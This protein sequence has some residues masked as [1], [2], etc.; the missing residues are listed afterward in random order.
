MSEEQFGE[1]KFEQLQGKVM[2]DV[3]GAMGLGET[4]WVRLGTS[5]K[6]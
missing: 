4:R 6:H 1:V 3:G 5:R 2:A